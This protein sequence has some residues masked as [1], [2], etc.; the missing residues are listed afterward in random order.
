M[1]FAPIDPAFNHPF[2]PLQ[3]TGGGM[4]A[5]TLYEAAAQVG[6]TARQMLLAAAAGLWEVDAASLRTENGVVTDGSRRVRYGALAEGGVEA[7]RCR[8]RHRWNRKDF[9][10]IGKSQHRLDDRAKVTGRGRPSAST[11]RCRGWCSRRSRMRRRS[12]RR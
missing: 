7:C 6:A 1:E 3:F 4:S 8:R 11:S 5:M 2:M 12:A 9:K 10:Y